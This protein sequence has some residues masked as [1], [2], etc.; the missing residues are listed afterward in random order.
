MI[1]LEKED[2]SPCTLSCVVSGLKPSSGNKEF[3]LKVNSQ[4]HDDGRDSL[5]CG[6]K[7]NKKLLEKIDEKEE[8]IIGE[9]IKEG[10]VLSLSLCT[11]L[12]KIW[13]L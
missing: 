6:I 7:R 1:P 9:M 12:Y 4:C 10:Y 3:G 5:Y 11:A 13:N 8:E 2:P